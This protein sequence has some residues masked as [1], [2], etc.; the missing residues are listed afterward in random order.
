MV[1]SVSNLTVGS[2]QRY[3]EQKNKFCDP[4]TTVD[5]KD[6]A[7]V[8]LKGLDTLWFNT[9]TICNLQCRNC[10]IESSPLNDRLV[11]LKSYDVAAFLDELDRDWQ[12]SEIGFTGG[13]P[14][15]NKEIYNHI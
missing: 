5:G 2:L 13:E 4:F 15:M 11:Y 7:T 8:T 1:S 12:A 6:R 14:F 9:G 10:Y 3:S